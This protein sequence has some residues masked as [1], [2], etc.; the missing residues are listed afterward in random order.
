MSNSALCLMLVTRNESDKAVE[1]LKD[2]NGIVDEVVVMDSSDAEH[3]EK[4]LLQLKNFKHTHV[5]RLPPLG[6]AEPYREYALQKVCSE[7]VLMLDSDERINEP[8]KNDIKKLLK[9]TDATVLPIRRIIADESEPSEYTLNNTVGYKKRL[10]R[11]DSA[12]FW[13]LVHE[14]PHVH[15]LIKPLD[16]KY[17]IVHYVDSKRYWHKARRYIKLEVFLGRWRYDKY[18]TTSRI[19]RLGLKAYTGIRGRSMSDEVTPFDLMLIKRLAAPGLKKLTFQPSEYLKRKI[20]LINSLRQPTRKLTFEVWKDIERFKG[21]IAYLDLTSD[22]T[23]LNIEEKYGGTTL[24][25][26]DFFI[27]LLIEKFLE[28]NPT[29]SPQ[30]EIVQIV[31]E[32]NKAADTVFPETVLSRTL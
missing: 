24:E 32:L 17:S 23:W 9:Q 27:S 8:L 12:E 15:G 22:S 14:Q 4:L 11:K 6:L 20:S 3:R 18:A 21:A 31:D 7:W 26:D 5:F 29:H 1:L 30:V 13:G 16:P 2:L 19:K 10:F 25:A 28:R